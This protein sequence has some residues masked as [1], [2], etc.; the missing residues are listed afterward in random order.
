MANNGKGLYDMGF[1]E[2]S[3]LHSLAA[4]EPPS[5]ASAQAWART[6]KIT[7][8]AWASGVYFYT[9]EADGVSFDWKKM[10]IIK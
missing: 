2:I 6:V 10:V 4:Q 8:H 9:L 5:L 1:L 3:Y 7:T